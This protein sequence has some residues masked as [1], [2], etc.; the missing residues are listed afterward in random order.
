MDDQL[1]RLRVNQLLKEKG[2]KQIR[3]GEMAYALNLDWVAGYDRLTE[4]DELA[5][6]IVEHCLEWRR[7]PGK[8]TDAPDESPPVRGKLPAP[9]SWW[10]HHER[11]IVARYE[12]DRRE[13][14]MLFGLPDVDGP[15][16]AFALEE[17]LDVFSEVA[18][19]EREEGDWLLLEW[20]LWNDDPLGTEVWPVWRGFHARPPID[21]DG[22]RSELGP[23]DRAAEQRLYRLARTAERIANET[24]CLESDAVAFLLCGEQLFSPYV[25]VAYDPRYRGYVIVV[26]DARIPPRDVER[27]YRVLSRR[28]GPMAR[29]PQEGPYVVVEFVDQA[30]AR[31]PTLTWA[32]LYERFSEGHPGRYGSMA[33]FRQ[34]YYSKKPRK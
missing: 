6:M 21:R 11:E 24:G 12:S 18:R 5:D 10:L 7:A 27:H 31:E 15:E 8:S 4:E 9:P 13:M 22:V 16:G 3:A 1:L 26:R 20:P 29:R 2:E 17:L 30:L 34:T 23:S 25:D 32:E 28:F 33:S 14:R 19:S